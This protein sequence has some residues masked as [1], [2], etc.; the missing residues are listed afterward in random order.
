MTALRA[1]AVALRQGRRVGVA[2]EGTRSRTGH[3]G[4]LHRVLI[5]LALDVARRD[6]PVVLEV[7]TDPEVPPLPPH[8][9]AQ[10]AKMLARALA[11]GDPARTEI[12]LQAAKG[13]LQEF[14]N[15]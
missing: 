7:K 12:M 10:E 3:L 5:K 2:A 14:V 6:V 4:P 11:K 9:T 15:R 13:K 1:I 8:I